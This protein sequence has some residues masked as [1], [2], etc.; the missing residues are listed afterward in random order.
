MLKLIRKFRTSNI[1]KMEAQTT[2]DIKANIDTV[3]AKIQTA[4]KESE[5]TNRVNLVSVT[6]RIKK[7]LIRQ[8]Y[9]HGERHFGENYVS[10]STC[11]I[12]YFYINPYH[13]IRNILIYC[14]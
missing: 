10:V 5:R 13:I 7:D 1:F 6:K 4:V 8:A 9:E 12:T 11:V 14:I 2:P 3:K